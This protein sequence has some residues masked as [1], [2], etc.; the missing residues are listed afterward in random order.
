M[1]LRPL[2]ATGT[3][4]PSLCLGTMTFGLQCDE[5]QSVAIL[6]RAWE[7]GLWF[8][9]TADVYPL[10]GDLT[11][12][13]RTEEILG[14]WMQAKGNR[15]QVFLATKCRGAMGS[16]PNDAGLSRHHIERAVDASLRRLKTDVIDLYQVHFFDP[17]TP[18]DETLSALDNLQR[19]GKVRYI[20]C[21]N[22]PAWR[23]MQALSASDRRDLARF[24]CVQ[25][26][27]NLLYRD[28]E[29]EL[30]PL[31]RDENVGVIVY[32]PIAGG[33][34][35]GKYKPQDEPQ[36]GTRFTMGYAG[37]MYQ[38]RYWHD[39]QLSIVEEI[40]KAASERGVDPVSVAVAW[41]IRQTGVTSAIIGASRPDQLD[42]TLAGA[43]FVIDDELMALCDAA[44]WRLPRR[45]VVDGYR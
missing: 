22:Y 30:L 6:D 5:E 14:R 7:G 20:G 38:Q 28:I 12:A 17:H 37:D 11:T 19:K 13:G 34:L 29:S 9:D 25:P 16:G 31:C 42:A 44:W 2:G 32:N 24:Q 8:H 43:E 33:L 1:E 10:G 18:I 4:V 45:P 36:D 23:L 21:S 39:E 15:D 26:R 27:Y 40:S 41:V 35:S 3:R